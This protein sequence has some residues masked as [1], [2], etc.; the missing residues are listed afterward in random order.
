M[1]DLKPAKKKTLDM[2]NV[3]ERGPFNPVQ[4]D[5]G[6]Y[7]AKITAVYDTESKKSGEDMWVFSFQLNER[8]AAVYPY[9]C[10][11]NPDNLWKIRNLCEAAGIAVPKKRLVLDP[12]K[13][14]GKE[15]GVTLEDDEYDGKMK[16]VIQAIFPANELEDDDVSPTDDAD[17]DEDETAD[18]V[19]D[20]EEEE[21]PARKSKARKA[22]PSKKAAEPEDDEDVDEDDLEEL[23]VDEL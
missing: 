1:A 12:N 7:R 2:T 3:K 19:E 8:R 9:Y 23:D 21:P 10:L 20:D 15:V 14:V 22:K 11:L 5:A 4:V 13:L 6:D 18:D 16:S 17:D